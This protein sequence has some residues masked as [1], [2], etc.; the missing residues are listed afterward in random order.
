MG[1]GIFHLILL[2]K[3]LKTS[4]TV[5][6]NRKVKGDGILRCSKWVTPIITP[7]MGQIYYVQKI[8]GTKILDMECDLM[9]PRNLSLHLRNRISDMEGF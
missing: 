2:G 5:K 1:H 6:R 3:V 9:N 4:L 7:E 8:Y